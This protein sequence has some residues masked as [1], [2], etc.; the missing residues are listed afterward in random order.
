MISPHRPVDWGRRGGVEAENSAS[1]DRRQARHCQDGGASPRQAELRSAG[2]TCSHS[3][4][5][6][7][8][9][10]SRACT[11]LRAAA[12]AWPAGREVYPR[13][14]ARSRMLT[15]RSSPHRMSAGLNSLCAA[16]I[17]PSAAANSTLTV[18]WVGRV[19]DARRG[20]GGPPAFPCGACCVTRRSKTRPPGDAPSPPRQDQEPNA[21]AYF[22]WPTFGARPDSIRDGNRCRCRLHRGSLRRGTSPA[23]VSNRDPRR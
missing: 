3:Q 15:R 6:F 9:C 5:G 17:S 14:V 21:C 8:G 2:R 16:R 13:A 18:A 10:L 1:C 23:P 19:R 7:A 20:V 22:R 12:E 11:A 4:R